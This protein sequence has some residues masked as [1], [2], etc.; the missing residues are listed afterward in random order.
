MCVRYD[1]NDSRCYWWNMNINLN[2]SITILRQHTWQH[3]VTL[4]LTVLK[5]Q[6]SAVPTP[7]HTR[8]TLLHVT[9]TRLSQD[10]ALSQNSAITNLNRIIGWSGIEMLLLYCTS[11]RLRSKAGYCIDRNIFRIFILYD[12]KVWKVKKKQNY[13]PQDFWQWKKNWREAFNSCISSSVQ[14]A[15]YLHQFR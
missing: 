4:N 2:G 9:I 13:S 7:N 10:S 5:I 6:A 14:I 12:M 15:V 11:T 8:V 3:S 1:V